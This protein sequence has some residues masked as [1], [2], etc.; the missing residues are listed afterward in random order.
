MLRKLAYIE[1]LQILKLEWRIKQ[2]KVIW[3][4]TVTSLIY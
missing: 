4:L 2:K 3:H 1:N